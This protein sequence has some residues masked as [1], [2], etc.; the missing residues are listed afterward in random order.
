MSELSASPHYDGSPYEDGISNRQRRSLRG[1]SKADIRQAART[2]QEQSGIRIRISRPVKN[3]L[4]FKPELKAWEVPTQARK[5]DRRG[6]GNLGITV[7]DTKQTPLRIGTDHDKASLEQLMRDYYP[8]LFKESP[9]V[10][11]AGVDLFGKKDKL[12]DMPFVGLTFL[13]GHAHKEQRTVRDLVAPELALDDSHQL[14]HR[15]HVSL[16]TATSPDWGHRMI[17]LVEPVVPK[18]VQFN[19]GIITVEYTQ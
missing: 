7:F 16:G 17:E 13:Y 12:T 9:L 14:D 8:A 11:V 2:A 4:D 5:T 19:P 6:L 1:P 3:Q 15:P 18:F 10:E